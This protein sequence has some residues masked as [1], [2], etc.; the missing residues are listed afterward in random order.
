[1]AAHIRQAIEASPAPCVAEAVGLR[2][3]MPG[4][5]DQVAQ[6]S[7]AALGGERARLPSA[8][9]RASGAGRCP[10]K[11]EAAGKRQ[12]G[13]TTQGRPLLRA[14]LGPAAWAASHSRGTSLAAPS[15]RRGTRMGTKNARGAVAHRMLVIVSHLVSRRTREVALGEDGF[16]RRRVQAPSQRLI[17]HLEALGLRVTVEGHE[18]AAEPSFVFI[19]GFRSHKRYNR[20]GR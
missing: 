19:A 18:E 11:H 17:R 6:T 1:M 5:G 15:H 14:A 9:P 16:K 3:T 8:G 7:V 2:E 20:S 13:K 4:V 12:S 10:G